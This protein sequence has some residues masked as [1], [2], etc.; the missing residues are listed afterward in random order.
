MLSAY[1]NKS[2][3]NYMFENMCRVLAY[4]KSVNIDV[5]V[6]NFVTEYQYLTQVKAHI[7]ILKYYQNIFQARLEYLSPVDNST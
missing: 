4:I 3:Q 7:S 6:H 5:P 2:C 1:I